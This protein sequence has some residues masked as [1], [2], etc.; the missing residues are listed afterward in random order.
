MKILPLM[1]NWV[2]HDCCCTIELLNELSKCDKMRG[3]AAEVAEDF[4]GS[5][6]AVCLLYRCT[7]TSD[8]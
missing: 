1:I 3:V 6:V 2:L 7:T 8:K 5:L 4:A